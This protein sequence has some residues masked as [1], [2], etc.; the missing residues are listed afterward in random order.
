[1]PTALPTLFVSHGA[2]T[3]VLDPIPTRGFLRALGQTLPCP[4]A[5]LCVS[6]HW[7]TAAPRLSSAL[8]PQTMYD[9][10]GFPD[11]LYE[12]VYPAPGDPALAERV[13]NL[14]IDAQIPATLD[15]HR[16]LDH[17]AWVPLSL[18]HPLADIPVVQLSIQSHL[19]PGHH[20]ELGQALAPL[21]EE[22]VLIMASGNAT[23]NLREAFSHG[24]EEAPV[25]YAKAFADWLTARIEAGDTAA[26]LDY[27]AQG[28][29]GPLN[30]PTPEHYL[31]LLVTLGAALGAGGTGATGLR[32]HDGYTFG[33]L[34]MAAY[35][36]N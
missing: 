16:G 2:P 6:A 30:H 31:P 11:E 8:R 35:A 12:L 24:M 10:Y 1:M 17:G 7:D 23:H 33:V 3:L 4:R 22:G 13:A 25:S 29:F 20:L 32:L 5:I 34:S 19:P 9:F 36:W 28:P 18:M 26:L 14:L 27:L 15:D 21:R